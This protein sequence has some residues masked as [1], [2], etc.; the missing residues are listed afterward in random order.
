M[1]SKDVYLRAAEWCYIGDGHE[2]GSCV[3]IAI[4]N[5]PTHC[6]KYGWIDHQN[7]DDVIKYAETFRPKNHKFGAYW[8]DID[9]DSSEETK[10]RRIIALLLAHQMRQTGDL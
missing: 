8:M 3:A 5:D 2:E 6:E 1:S 9:S 10:N 7:D 4:A